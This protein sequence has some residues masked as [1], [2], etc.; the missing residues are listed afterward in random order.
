M[1]ILYFIPAVLS[2]RFIQLEVGSWELKVK[3]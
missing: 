1:S 2:I 3:K